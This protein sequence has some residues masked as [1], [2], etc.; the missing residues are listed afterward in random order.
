MN[1]KQK[2]IELANIYLKFFR[3]RFRYNLFSLKNVE[4]TKWWSSFYKAVSFFS[5]DKKW[6]PHEYIIFLF[7]TFDKPFPFMLLYQKNWIAFLEH[8][9][10]RSKSETAIAR[11]IVNTYNE[12]KLWTKKNNYDKLAVYDFFSNK[13][14]FL[15]LKSKRYSPY[16]LAISKSFMKK[17]LELSE[18]E[19]KEIIT[20]EELLIKRVTVKNDKKL[21]KKLREVLGDEYIG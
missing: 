2:T 11:S 8:K 3:G 5:K 18:E 16:F 9:E 14:N 21:D 1:E 17:Y 20:K 19:R 13:K 7:D 6:N 15:Y 10:S 12:I 4:N